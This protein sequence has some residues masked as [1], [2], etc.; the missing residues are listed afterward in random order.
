MKVVTRE[1]HKRWVGDRSISRD[2]EKRDAGIRLNNQV[3]KSDLEDHEERTHRFHI[4]HQEAAQQQQSDY[5]EWHLEG[6]SLLEKQ[7]EGTR[8]ERMPDLSIEQL[9]EQL[10]LSV[11]WPEVQDLKG[12]LNDSHSC[13]YYFTKIL[14][15]VVGPKTARTGKIAE[16]LDKVQNSN[17]NADFIR[18][19][20]EV[21]DLSNAK[22]MDVGAVL[23]VLQQSDAI[24]KQLRKKLEQSNSQRVTAF[25]REDMASA[26]AHHNDMDDILED[27]VNVHLERI[28]LLLSSGQGE[29]FL[30]RLDEASALLKKLLE[31]GR[32]HAEDVSTRI[33]ADLDRVENEVKT[34]TKAQDDDELNMHKN[35]TKS[36]QI[37]SENAAAQ[38]AKFEEIAKLYAELTALGEE[39][40]GHIADLVHEKEQQEQRTAAFERFCLTTAEHKA[41]LEDLL[42]RLDVTQKTYDGTERFIQDTKDSMLQT[43]EV[44]KRETADILL[45]ERRDYYV[46]FREYYTTLGDLLYSKEKRLE[47]TEDLMDCL[48]QKLKLSQV[49]LD[50]NA[51]NYR[52]QMKD[53][54]K[55]KKINELEIDDLRER[56]DKAVEDAQDTEDALESAGDEIMSPAIELQEQNA[57]RSEMVTEARVAGARKKSEDV[58]RQKDEMNKNLRKAKEVKA[59]KGLSSMMRPLSPDPSKYK[60]TPVPQMT[61]EERRML[62][63]QRKRNLVTRLRQSVNAGEDSGISPSVLQM[64]GLDASGVSR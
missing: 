64:S 5:R 39:R 14:K 38:T 53:L 31:D 61:P 26:E 9:I 43:T 1:Q 54:M 10:E 52:E 48:E 63:E 6:S 51:H 21:F 58:E 32:A 7:Q 57:K 15:Q 59:A 42:G 41:M 4:R 50:K 33:Q 34:R 19:A 11:K 13:D 44:A 49:C 17:G 28:D 36:R 45:K 35:Q 56:A 27:L 46:S 12:R 37:L 30:Q 20:K 40:R 2:A 3:L 62:M 23:K 60:H 25:D 29:A 55:A 8:W 47:E 22:P 18:I 16:D 24:L